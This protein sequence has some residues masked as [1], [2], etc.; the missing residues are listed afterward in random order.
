[1]KSLE[2]GP[3]PEVDCADRSIFAL[4]GSC[5]VLIADWFWLETNLAWERHDTTETRRL[6]ALT[7]AAD[8][9]SRYY[10][11][12]SAR[13]LAYDFPEW[14][15]ESDPQAPIVVQRRRTEIAA[16]EALE[17]LQRAAR[18]QRRCVAFEIEMANIC[19]YALEDRTRAAGHYRRAAALPDAPAYAARIATRLEEELHQP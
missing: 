6:I 11:L 15:K 3:E 8:S 16:E 12:N 2:P 7:L 17:L 13:I 5:R 1:M 10:W 14:A 4:A 9:A 18:R 19:L